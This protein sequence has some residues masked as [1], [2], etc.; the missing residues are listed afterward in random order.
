ME[1]VVFYFFAGVSV[2]AALTVVFQSTA[3]YGVLSLIVCFGAMA[4]LF[5]QLGAHFLAAIQ[6]IVYAGAIMVLFLFVT[7]LLDPES[8]RFPSNRLVKT[9]ILALPVAAFLA[10]LLLQALAESWPT[11]DVGQEQTGRIE[12]IAAY[13]FRD[14]LLPFEITSILVLAAIVGAVVLVKRS[15]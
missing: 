1:H 4:V 8:E 12:T 15:D 5:F 9:T 13:L 11:L 10:L 7:M 6:V 3:I 14:Y 2:I